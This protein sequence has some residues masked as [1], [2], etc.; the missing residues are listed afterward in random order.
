MLFSLFFWDIALVQAEQWAATQALSYVSVNIIYVHQKTLR[1]E[2]VSSMFLF[3]SIAIHSVA[4]YNRSGL[5]KGIYFR[6]QICFT[7]MLLM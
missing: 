5:I 4:I 3:S 6:L 2:T 7:T 1:E